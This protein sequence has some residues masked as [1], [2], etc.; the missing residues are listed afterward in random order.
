[1]KDIKK[2]AVLGSGVMGSGIAALLANSG[3]DVLLLDIVPKDAADRNML[4]KGAIDKQLKAKPASGFTHPKNA[5]RVTPGN[6]EDDLEKLSDC[7]WVVEVVLERLDV[8]HDVYRKILPYLKPEAVLS[9]NTSTIPLAELEK[10]MPEELKHRFLLTHFFNPPRFL[11]LLEVTGGKD[12]DP[13]IVAAMRDFADIR[14]GKGVVTCKDT[15][16]FLGNRIGVYWLIQ[17]LLKAMELGISVEDADAVMGKPVGIP[18]TGVFGLFDL[19]G[20]DLMPHIAKSMLSTLPEEDRFRRIYQEPELIKKLI[21]EGYTGRKGKGGFYRMNAQD[22]K[23]VKEAIDL[24][25]GEYHAERKSAL[26][27]VEAAKDG[28]AA[29]VSHPDIGGR[30]AKAVLVETLWYAA[31]LVP[32]ISDDILNIDAAMRLG[33]NWKYGPFELIDRLGGADVLAAA[34]VEA[35]LD[36]PELLQIASGK[37]FYKEEGDKRYYLTAKGEYAPVETPKGAWLL[38]DKIRGAQPV[39]KTASAK[40]WDLG[41]GML[42]FELTGKGNTFDPDVMAL[43]RKSHDVV[44]SGFRGM[45]IGHDGENFSFGANL[46]FFMYVANLAA[47]EMLSGV[48]KE[49]QQT[50]M[51]LKYAPFPVVGAPAGMA[52]GGGCEILLHCDAVQAHSETYAGLVEVGVGVIPGWGGCKEMLLRVAQESRES[53]VA[54]GPMPVVSRAFEQ[55]AMAKVSGSAQEAREMLILNAASGVT[56]NR[57]RVL[58]DAKALAVKLAEGYAPPE[59]RTIRLPGA[60]GKAALMMAL[61]QYREQG[62]ATPH[63]LVVGEHL[64]TVLSGGATDITEE[65]S[66]QNLLD[67]EHDVFMQLVKTNATLDRIEHMLEIG[68]P[69]RN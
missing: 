7:D 51:G 47:W 6:L 27:S 64:A 60:S 5:K 3:M 23:K 67:L 14:L 41:D 17:G 40:L 29:L 26:K 44:K 45:V 48:I 62:K 43:L 66:E 33:Y 21:A 18:K 15:P 42:G 11:P 2:A 24:A 65:L 38:K 52:F 46:G 31:V 25:T 4:A 69:L 16:G 55:I 22:G 37:R 49:G 56:M 68:K 10:G 20:I 50:Y 35:G 63:D 61:D 59:P 58:A 39:A 13:A 36:V 53:R 12:C 57:T 34:C 8:K 9:T 30:Y 28:L 19:I 54:S 32:E 1:M